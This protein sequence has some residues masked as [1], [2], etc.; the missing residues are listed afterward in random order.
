MQA[1]RPKTTSDFWK[2][3][4][5]RC[6]VALPFF[7]V[8]LFVIA[9]LYGP[10]MAN[11]LQ[12]N[13]GPAIGL[14]LVLSA[15]LVF[16]NAIP[17]VPTN[18]LPLTL[19]LGYFLGL[20]TPTAMTWLVVAATVVATAGSALGFI[21]GRNTELEDLRL[22]VWGLKNSPLFDPALR[23]VEQHPRRTIFFSR[24]WNSGRLGHVNLAAGTL[25][26]EPS[27]F[28]GPA[29]YGHFIW[30]IFYVTVGFFL[31]LLGYTILG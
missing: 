18:A 9:G 19:G 20:F 1:Q 29:F 13:S 16:G 23:D 25:W 14:L 4:P 11:W 17:G 2:K 26:V 30:M 8:F 10:G 21:I 3:F 7:L 28:I 5:N 31:G 22:G 12:V 24:F 27:K 15:L 6:T